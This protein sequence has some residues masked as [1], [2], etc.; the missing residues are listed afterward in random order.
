MQPHDA[1]V[2]SREVWDRLAGRYDRDIRF[3]EAKL[4]TGGREWVCSRAAGDVLEVAVGTGRNLDFYPGDVRLT[5]LELSPAMLA[6]ARRRAAGLGRPIALHEGDAQALP[7]RD[8]SFDTVVCVLSL[9]A[10][11]DAGVALAEMRRVLRPGGRLL[12]LDHVAGTRAA[13]RAVQWLAE[14]VTLP[15]QGEHLTRRTLPMVRAAGFD[16]VEQERLKAGIVQRIHA[17]KPAG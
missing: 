12:L 8:A 15:L 11:T 14:R 5:G 4:F 2:R 3:L 16:V 1:S 17:R 7:Y 9:C 10:I 13:V 6:V